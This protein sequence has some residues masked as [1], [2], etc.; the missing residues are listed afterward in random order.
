[1]CMHDVGFIIAS[2]YN[3]VV[4]FL[5]NTQNLNFFPHAR[6]P[7]EE[8][9]VCVMYPTLICGYHF[10]SVT[11]KDNAPLPN[12]LACGIYFELLKHPLGRNFSLI[13]FN[14][15]KNDI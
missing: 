15:T 6:Q 8:N 14:F 12:M 10:V 13:D 2:T 3:C 11:L 7:M 9:E 4:V 5:S 1:M